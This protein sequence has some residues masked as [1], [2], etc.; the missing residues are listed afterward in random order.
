MAE[1]QNPQQE[2]GA[3][4]RLL[5]AFAAMI[6]FLLITQTFFNRQAPVPQT[7]SAPQNP[8]PVTQ[9]Q[10]A[11]TPPPSAP[12]APMMSARQAEKESEMVVENALYRIRFSNRGAQVKSWVLKQY[13]DDKGQPL[14]LVNAKAAEKMGLPLSLWTYDE[15]LRNKLSS[16]LYT[17][18]ASSVRDK[19]GAGPLAPVNG[20][21]TV[22]D[23]VQFTFEY[24]DGETEARKSFRFD[25][26]YVM[27]I[28]TSVRQKGAAVQAYP[29]W[30]A[31]F[32]DQTRSSSFATAQIVWQYGETIERHPPFQKNFFSANRWVAG[33]DTI[34]GPFHW[35][36][37][38]DQYFAA[39]FLPDDPGASAMV[40]LHEEIDISEHRNADD[41]EMKVPV[42]GTAVGD[43]GGVT[44]ERL[45][46]GPK[47]IEVLESVHA[48]STG[49]L[50]GPNLEGTLDYGF[51]GVIA[52][53]L[54]LWLKWTYHNI[55]ANWGWSI[56]V[57]TIVINLGI[58]PLRI[59]GMRQAL[60]MQKLQPQLDSIRK[61][62]EKYSLRDPKRAEMNQ[63]VWELQ[64][65]S[66]VNPAGGCL[67]ML[68]QMPI[69]LAFYNMLTTANELRQAHWMWVPDLS[70]PDPWHIL[71]I[72]SVVTMLL[73]QSMTPTPG[74]DPAQRR[75]MNIMM[76]AMFGFFTWAVA[77]GLA[78]YW[79]VGSILGGIQQ[80]AMNRS[81]LGREIREEAEKRARKKNK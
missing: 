25:H 71:P 16:A 36:G 51:F 37:V 78:L 70:S 6:I 21:Y 67:P 32:G 49:G 66:G 69:L 44:R 17:A 30:P 7:P 43:R 24:S 56:V 41:K 58:L 76:P 34:K 77:S 48:S 27:K 13:K 52:K 2:P 10:T 15:G 18:S 11:A 79:T 33:G 72:L 5:L 74:M 12:A 61:K 29:A 42:L 50:R 62:Y 75:M 26:S 40:T 57:L 54:F 19:I 4:K 20:V 8:A 9:P 59:A 80:F 64:K 68:L 39:V 53:L 45:F 55:V 22:T 14:E 47:A 65:K 1:Y 28:E 63:E 23:P 60:K 46:V 35:A 3:E 38:S 31:G 81:K 73:V